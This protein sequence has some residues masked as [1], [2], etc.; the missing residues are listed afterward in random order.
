MIKGQEN[1]GEKWMSM[2][3]SQFPD[4]VNGQALRRM[5]A[6]GDDLSRPR[7]I[8]F[9]F[10]FTDEQSAWSFGES[11]QDNCDGIHIRFADPTRPVVTV[12][13]ILVPDHSLITRFELFLTEKALSHGGCPDGWG[14]MSV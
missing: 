7:R 3:P 2:S 5:A 11:I 6:A 1:L 14:S 4:D 10:V 8:E 9:Y 12:R 13:R